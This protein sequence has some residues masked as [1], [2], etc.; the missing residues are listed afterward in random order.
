MNLGIDVDGVLGDF[1]KSMMEWCRKIT[2]RDLFPPGYQPHTWNYPEALG[3]TNEEVS[4]MWSA[5]KRDELFWLSLDG[6]PETPAAIVYL[7]NRRAQGDDIYFITN[8]VGVRA[9]G[10]TEAWLSGR[11]FRQP[12]VL[13]SGEK[14]L[15][16]KALKLDA[17]IDD[18]WENCVDVAYEPVF[19]ELKGQWET[20]RTATNVFLMDRPWNSGQFDPAVCRVQAVQLMTEATR[21][22][23]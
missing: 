21:T 8:R 12:T 3:Y 17:Y 18:K 4:A 13:L 9:K 23:G 5:I 1:N 6:Y 22:R 11:G 16:A 19:N 2:G 7:V 15:C 10:Q 20:R 14:G